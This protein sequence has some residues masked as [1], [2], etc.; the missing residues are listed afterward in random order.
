MLRVGE[1]PQ[2]RARTE[3]T[4]DFK[5]MRGVHSHFTYEV[6]FVT[7]GHLTLV[8]EK[9]TTVYERKIV[10]I[11]PKIKHYSVPDRNGSFCLLFSF[12][13]PAGTTGRRAAVYQRKCDAR[14]AEICELPLSDETAFYIQKIAEKSTKNTATTEKS[15]ELLT[16]LVFHDIME[17]LVETADDWVPI[18]SD[19]K[20]IGAIEAFVNTHLH[21]KF[22]LQDVATQVFLSTRQVSRILTK[23]YGCSLSEMVTEKRLASAEMLVKNTN[24]P[25]G[26][27]AAQTQ[28]GSASYFYALFKKRYGVSPLQ[29]RKKQRSK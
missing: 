17:Q 12:E 25:I 29:Y 9:E 16:A 15:A 26:E 7:N 8:T 5:L 24:L 18:K 21:S 4:D 20:H 2:I 22:T 10:I 28:I 14:L 6:F 1:N 19:S 11:P 27:I 3:S 23:E 13:K